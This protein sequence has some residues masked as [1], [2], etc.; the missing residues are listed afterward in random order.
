M[1][2]DAQPFGVHVKTWFVINF[3]KRFDIGV[4]RAEH[5]AGLNLWQRRKW[6]VIAEPALTIVNRPSLPCQQ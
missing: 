1:G 5:H 2:L 6:Q 4:L 3:L